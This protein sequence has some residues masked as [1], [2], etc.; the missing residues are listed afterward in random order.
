MGPIRDERGLEQGGV[1]SSDFYKIFGKDQLVTAQQ[2]GL[3]VG[4]GVITV[5]AIGKADDTALVSNDINDI[6]NLLNLS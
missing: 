3:G 2:S 1:N 6:Q 5:A 4:L